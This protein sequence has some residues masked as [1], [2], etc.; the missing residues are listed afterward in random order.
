VRLPH[1]RGW[2]R[3]TADCN[4]SCNCMYACCIAV[5]SSRGC[6]GLLWTGHISAAS[7]PVPPPHGAGAHPPGQVSHLFQ[8]SVWQHRLSFQKP[9]LPSHTVLEQ[10]C[11]R[12][13][14]APAHK[15]RWVQ[16]DRCVLLLLCHKPSLRCRSLAAGVIM[17]VHA[18]HSLGSF[19]L[20]DRKRCCTRTA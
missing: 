11:Q 2:K 15:S 6:K 13:L 4:N 14:T 16:N 5:H 10:P 7:A 20:A 18:H 3:V 17:L 12:W 1:L 9:P 19:A 8:A